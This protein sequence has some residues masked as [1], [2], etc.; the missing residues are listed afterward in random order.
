MVHFE[1]QGDFQISRK[2]NGRQTVLWYCFRMSGNTNIITAIINNINARSNN[3]IIMTM[4]QRYSYQNSIV[5]K[6]AHPTPGQKSRNSEAGSTSS[7]NFGRSTASRFLVGWT[8]VDCGPYDRYHDIRITFIVRFII[9][10]SSDAINIRT[11]MKE[12]PKYILSTIY[13]P[14]SLELTLQVTR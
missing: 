12:K 2:I 8:S 9:G 13:I 7:L 5:L 14:P 1:R 11:H 10:S 4:A 6:K 3:I